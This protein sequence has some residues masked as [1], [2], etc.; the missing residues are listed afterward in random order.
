MRARRR[1]LAGMGALALSG[2]GRG[3][4][5]KPEASIEPGLP[6]SRRPTD[7]NLVLAVDCSRSVDAV[8]YRLQAEGYAAAFRNERVRRAILGG[9][10]KRI[11]IAMTHW[12]GQRVQ[13]VA[14]DWT[15]LDG[16]P[17]LDAFAARL[18][19]QPRLTE[20]DAT[21]LGAAIDHGRLLLECC[22]F[23]SVR[24]VIDI[25]GDGSNNQGKLARY[26]RDE[27]VAVDIGINGL[28]ILTLEP[29][30]DSIYRAE[31]IGGPGAFVVPVRRY[32]DFAAA[33]ANK[34]VREIA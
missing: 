16:R 27:A 13:H 23:A 3:V 10:E 21:A 6:F 22:P 20:D 26:A 24:Q 17:A 18:A 28:P 9:R 4:L 12:G 15:L 7:L 11:A 34:L 30:L 2:A 19:V 31:V 1:F 29:N 14:V 32:A 25:S 8:R 5:A 33:L